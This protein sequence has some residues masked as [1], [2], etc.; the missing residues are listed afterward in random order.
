MTDLRNLKVLDAAYCLVD[1]VHDAASR[2]DAQRV[3]RLRNQ[4]L[5]AT[6]AVPANIAE[7][8]RGSRPQF[9]ECL[10]V[11]L[12]SADES[13]AHLMMAM[14]VRALPITDFR[15]CEARRAVVCKMLTQLIRTVEE[16]HSRLAQGGS[17]AQE[18][19]KE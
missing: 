16:Q 2:I 5:R 15:R 3:P 12:R 4:L 19:R 10:R 11:A 17:G 7:G 13:G 8:A 9:A 1:A 6:A 14:R 18:R